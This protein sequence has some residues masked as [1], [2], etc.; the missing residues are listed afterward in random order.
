MARISAA[1]SPWAEGNE[2]HEHSFAIS[3]NANYESQIPVEGFKESE[4][5]VVLP[6]LIY[7]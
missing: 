6:A 7:T 3:F 5:V 4:N 1:G 2:L